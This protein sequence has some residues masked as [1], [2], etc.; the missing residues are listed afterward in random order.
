MG[1]IKVDDCTKLSA[2]DMKWLKKY[3]DDPNATSEEGK[4]AA[5]RAMRVSKL[6]NY[7]SF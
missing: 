3:M 5:K 7:N 1:R 4:Q 2:E 6:L